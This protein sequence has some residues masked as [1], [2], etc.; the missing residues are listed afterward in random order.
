MSKVQTSFRINKELLLEFQHALID[1]RE[2]MSPLIEKLVQGWV[3]QRAQRPAETEDHRLTAV[4]DKHEGSLVVGPV[5]PSLSDRDRTLLTKIDDAL[6]AVLLYR[7]EADA[8]AQVA[9]ALFEQIPCVLVVKDS[10]GRM[11]WANE[12]FQNVVGKPWRTYEGQTA[13]K[14]WKNPYGTEILK[15]DLQ[16]AREGKPRFFME[17]VPVGDPKGDVI[18]VRIAVRFPLRQGGTRKVSMLAVM[19]FEA[20]ELIGLVEQVSPPSPKGRGRSLARPP[21]DKAIREFFRWVPANTIVAPLEGNKVAGTTPK[22][23]LDR[24]KKEPEQPL[25]DVE[26]VEDTE[27]LRMWFCGALKTGKPPMFGC[28]S[29]DL[30]IFEKA[31]QLMQHLSIGQL[32]FIECPRV[33]GPKALVDLP[34]DQSTLQAVIDSIPAVAVVKDLESRLVFANRGFADFSGLNREEVVSQRRYALDRWANLS[35]LVMTLDSFV[36]NHGKPIVSIEKIPHG[37]GESSRIAYRFPIFDEKQRVVLTGTLSINYSET[38]R[39]LDER[40]GRGYPSKY[41]F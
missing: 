32:A 41:T 4:S 13:A 36:R 19:A 8:P 17:G 24:L 7:G 35:S 31:E 14:I 34:R 16:V 37:S 29:V 5:L 38:V 2:S 39:R 30:N 40:S 12:H 25:V 33:D 20:N 3:A 21:K 9:A 22:R 26:V 15:H 27:R 6:D 23:V 10:Q 1:E 28:T 11:R 18:R